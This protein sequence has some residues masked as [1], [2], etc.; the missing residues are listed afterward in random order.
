MTVKEMG[1]IRGSIILASEHFRGGKPDNS[2][3][4]LRQYHSL[5]QFFEGV[6]VRRTKG[7]GKGRESC[8]TKDKTFLS[9]V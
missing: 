3:C 8:I 2:C 7:E 1:F 9:R 5:S 6:L 4:R